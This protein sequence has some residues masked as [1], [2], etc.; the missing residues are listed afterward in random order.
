MEVYFAYNM[1]V[2]GVEH[3]DERSTR[4]WGPKEFAHIRF[5]PC[6]SQAPASGDV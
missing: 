5:S 1:L 6:L 2:L 4:E 3:S